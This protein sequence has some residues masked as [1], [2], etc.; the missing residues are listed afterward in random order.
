M[1]WPRGVDRH[2]D[3]N[4]DDVTSRNEYLFLV[5]S[6]FDNVWVRISHVNGVSR[7][8]WPYREGGSSAFDDHLKFSYEKKLFENV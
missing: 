1:A 6:M 3:V 8:N 4:P 7:P 2:R 5:S